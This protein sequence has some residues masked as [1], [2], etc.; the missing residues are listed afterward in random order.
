[1]QQVYRGLKEAPEVLLCLDPG[2]TTGVAVYHRAVLFDALQKSTGT[3]DVAL[4]AFQELFRVYTPT[5][6]V[7]ED[8][9][10]YNTR[11]A[12]HVG[13]SLSTPRLIGMIETLCMMSNVPYHKQ[14]AQT[15]KQFVTDPKLKAWG[16]YQRGSKH[17]RDA[18]R[19]G[20]YFILFPP[21]G[22]TSETHQIIKRTTGRH[23]G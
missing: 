11:A 15:P 22:L 7:M 19:H 13:S 18:M 12:Q 10:V 16:F 20:A 6:V 21:K 9:R 5:M 17:A 3:P 14:P 1:M 8:Y 23:V 2:E 4:I